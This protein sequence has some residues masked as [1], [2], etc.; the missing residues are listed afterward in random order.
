MA[1]FTS[2]K[3]SHIIPLSHPLTRKQAN[4]FPSILDSFSTEVGPEWYVASGKL[5]SEEGGGAPVVYQNSIKDQD[6]LYESPG[7]RNKQPAEADHSRL[8]HFGS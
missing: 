7:A 3:F 6:Y 5:N 8:P 1:E 2:T 4:K